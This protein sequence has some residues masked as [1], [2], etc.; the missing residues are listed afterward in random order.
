MMSLLGVLAKHWDAVERDLLCAGLHFDDLCEKFSIAEF[1]SFVLN[2][3]PGTAVYHQITEGWDVS[4]RLAAHQ[5]DVLNLLAWFKTEDGMNNRRRPEPTWQP[6]H[7]KPE[8][9]QKAMTI[10]DYM[11]LRGG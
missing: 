2:S 11:R 4:E 9:K 3:P 6:G 5:L 10:E 1:A 8:K 7:V